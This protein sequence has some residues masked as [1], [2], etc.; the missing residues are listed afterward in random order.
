MSVVIHR[1]SFPQPC[2]TN[3]CT[4][5]P[6][7]IQRLL[8]LTCFL[9]NTANRSVLNLQ[10]ADLLTNIIL[11]SQRSHLQLFHVSQVEHNQHTDAVHLLVAL[12][13]M[14][15]LSLKTL[16]FFLKLCFMIY[17]ISAFNKVKIYQAI[18]YHSCSSPV[19]LSLEMPVAPG[20]VID[21]MLLTYNRQ[22]NN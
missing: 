18:Y 21:E 14:K 5:V 16:I 7:G 12:Y 20:T 1:C 2:R 8:I 13:A 17:Q 19:P 9:C 10:Q 15:G 22:T 6:H 4:L 3:D 11:M